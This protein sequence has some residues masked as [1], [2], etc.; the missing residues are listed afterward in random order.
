[1]WHIKHKQPKNNNKLDVI[2]IKNFYA[3]EDIIKKP[4]KQLIWWETIFANH[5]SDKHLVSSVY[6]E[7]LELNNKKT[8]Q[9]KNG[10]RIW[11]DVF[12]KIWRKRE[13]EEVLLYKHTE[14][15]QKHLKRCS[16]LGKCK[17]NNN[18]MLLHTH[19]DDYN[20][21]HRQ[22]QVLRVMWRNWNPHM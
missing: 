19:W 13:R 21:K 15:W 1:M 10:K 11:I 6:K 20:E 5:V 16:T 18:R 17:L 4:K 9:F 7:Y 22:Q 2:K 3:S 12:L 8:I 14:N